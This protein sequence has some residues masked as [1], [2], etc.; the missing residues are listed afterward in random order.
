MLL[1]SALGL[2]WEWLCGSPVLLLPSLQ[3]GVCSFLYHSIIYTHLC[4]SNIAVSISNLSL[5]VYW[6]LCKFQP[7]MQ[8]P[9]YLPML[10]E[11]LAVECGMG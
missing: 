8:G 4:P 5:V 9:L 11:I 2:S 7:L 10:A 3:M 6:R 1:P